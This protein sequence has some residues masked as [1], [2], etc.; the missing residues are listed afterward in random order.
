MWRNLRKSKTSSTSFSIRSAKLSRKSLIPSSISCTIAA[1][2][3]KW[4]IMRKRQWRYWP[5]VMRGMTRKPFPSGLLSWSK[6]V[7]TKIYAWSCWKCWESAWRSAWIQYTWSIA[8]IDWRNFWIVWSHQK[9]KR[10]R[11]W[12]ANWFRSVKAKQTICRRKL[13]AKLVPLLL[14]ARCCQLHSEFQAAKR[15]KT[16][17]DHH[18]TFWLLLLKDAKLWSYCRAEVKQSDGVRVGQH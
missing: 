10:L 5:S 11:N 14:P 13:K 4:E 7:R 12:V 9:M 15:C 17:N 16:M 6:W 1:W 8:L 18:F 2:I 3:R